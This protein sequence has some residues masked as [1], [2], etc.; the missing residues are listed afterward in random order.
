M[1]LLPKRKSVLFRNF[2]LSIRLRNHVIAQFPI[3]LSELF[4]TTHRNHAH[5]CGDKLSVVEVIGPH[6]RFHNNL[7]EVLHVIVPSE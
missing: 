5:H 1:K 7:V 3:V 6:M 4:G 2:Q